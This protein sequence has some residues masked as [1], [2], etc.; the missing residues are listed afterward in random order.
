MIKSGSVITWSNLTHYCI[1]HLN[2]LFPSR[3]MKICKLVVLNDNFSILPVSSYLENFSWN[4]TRM[5]DKNLESTLFQVMAWC[6]QATRNYLSQCWHRSVMLYGIIGP[7]RVNSFLANDAIWHIILS[8]LA[9]IMACHRFGAK[10]LPE[11]WPNEFQWGS[12]NFI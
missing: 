5:D 10:T 6:H 12:L 8:L 3:C 7:Q 1:E 2:S 9:Q 11:W 4:Y